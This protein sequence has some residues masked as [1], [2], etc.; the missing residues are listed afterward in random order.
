MFRIYL[1]IFFLFPALAGMAAQPG[2][3]AGKCFAEAPQNVI[4]LISGSTRLDM[5][6]YFHAGSQKAS[7]NEAEGQARITAE[8][9]RSISFQI[10]EGITAQMFVLN[11]EADCPVIGYVETV[12][13]PVRDSSV[14]FFNCRWEPLDVFTMPVLADWVKSGRKADLDALREALPFIFATAEY[15]PEESALILTN[16]TAGYFAKSDCPQA[17]GSMRDQIKMHWTGKRFKK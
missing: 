5:L 17:L 13:L 6:D 2:L 7:L 12:S 15:D 10:S 11:P 1:L 4:P 14:R 9:P 16:T 8:T 3:T